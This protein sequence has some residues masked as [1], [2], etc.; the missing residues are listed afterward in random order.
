M[1]NYDDYLGI[2]LEAPLKNPTPPLLHTHAT[3]S[4]A[5]A[6]VAANEGRHDMQ[7][8]VVVKCKPVRSCG[9]RSSIE[10]FVVVICHYRCSAAYGCHAASASIVYVH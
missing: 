6:L 5:A 3:S 10:A 8:V 1:L 2:Q 4:T 7:E 9:F